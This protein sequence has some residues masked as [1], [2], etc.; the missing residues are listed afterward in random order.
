MKKITLVLLGLLLISSSSAFAADRICLKNSKKVNV[1]NNKVKIKLPD[2]IMVSTSA[3]PSGY[4]ELVQVDNFGSG[5]TMTGIWNLSGAA[6]EDYFASN[7]SFPKPLASAPTS[8]IFVAAGTND[9]ICT[10]SA[11]NP[12]APTGVLC[13]YEAL[14]SGMEPLLA[15]RYF[16][17][18]P[19]TNNISGALSSSSRFGAALYGYS[20]TSSVA[21]AWGIWAV[22]VP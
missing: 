11:S 7:I 4:T 20:D 3:C 5:T 9:T 2:I 12:T 22:M 10:G 16:S 17:Y 18:D 6:N 1:V 19:T 14:A 8:V 13:F 15:D 21:Y